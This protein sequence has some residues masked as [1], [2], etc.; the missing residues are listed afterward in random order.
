[1]ETLLVLIGLAV[2]AVPV[3]MILLWIGHAGLRARLDLAERRIAEM[4]VEIA[5]LRARPPGEALPEAMPSEAPSEPPMP[6]AVAQDMPAPPEPPALEDLSPWDRALR[7][8]AEVPEPDPEPD[9]NRPI[10][11]RPDRFAA[12]GRWLRENWVY[13]VSALSLALAGVFFVQYGMERGLLPPAARVAMAVLFGLALIGA[14]EW[15]RRRWGDGAESA[16]AYLPSVFS[17]A[18]IVAVFA[19]IT[20]GRLMYGLYGPGPGFA[21]LFAISALAVWLGWRHG[22]LLVAVGLLGATATPFLVDGGGSAAPWLYA[23]YLL[24]AATGLAV[25]A[26]RRWAWVSVLALALGHAGLAL[27]ALSGGGAVGWQWSLLVMVLL[28]IIIPQRAL[29]PDHPGPSIARA[30]WRRDGV[31]P[32]FPA[33]LAAANVALASLAWA[34]LFPGSEAMGAFL[35]LAVLAFLLLVWAEGAQGLEDLAALPLIGFLAKLALAEPMI[36]NW[37]DQRIVL[38]APETDPP[39]TLS[40]LLAMVT[41]VGLVAAWRSL[42]TGSL[43]HALAGVLAAPVAA[44]ILEAL[45]LPATVLGE[46]RWALHVMG[47]AALMA[48]LA[49]AFARADGA[50]GRRSAWAALSCLSLIAFALFLLTSAAALTLAL[51]VLLVAAVA[52]DRRFGLPEMGWFV[53]AGAAV[54][55]Y[56]LVADPGMDWALEAALTPVLAAHLGVALA[57]GA[58][59]RLLPEA[60]A[61]PRAV[62]ESLGLAALALLANVLILRQLGAETGTDWTTSHWSATLNALP[63]LILAATQLWRVGAMAGGIARLL[64]LGIAGLAGALGLSGLALAAGPLNPLFNGW[65]ED[66]TGHVLG[67]VLADTLLIAYGLPGLALIWLAPR[68]PVLPPALRHAL[69]GIGAALVV[70]YVGLEIRRLWQGPWIGG[71]GV[72]QGELY[73]YTLALML[74][75][76]ALLW[77]ALARR[78]PLLQRIAM[79]VIGLTVAKVF[80][81]D[82]SGLSGLTRVLSFA[83]LGLS[84]A[85]LAWLNRW[86]RGAMADTRD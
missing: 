22:P 7:R 27:M 57:C 66:R 56:R 9:Q 23:Y 82:V 73:S 40:L 84:L 46:W 29:V 86:A 77:Q 69:R 63:W 11:L 68:L 10:V 52:L 79:A 37:L 61:L 80:L 53:Q 5:G 51:A 85:G 54:L 25:D 72:M 18:G 33:R 76:A 78:S 83:G 71:P 8:A 28:S 19:G 15:L 42:R 16:T 12:L 81:W 62:L 2:L 50:P 36:W 13:A 31:W 65:A 41:A 21:G 44:L 26:F 58:A 59:L 45:W 48:G 64:R 38:R 17:G 35:L 39:A 14:G 43:P 75:G 24:I 49:T 1:M 34:L 74:T 60:R 70:L 67:P 3:G 32:G 47:L 20:A 55:S 30:L 6:E 4:A